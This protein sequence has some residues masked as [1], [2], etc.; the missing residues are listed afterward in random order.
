MQTVAE[1]NSSTDGG[2][3]SLDEDGSPGLDSF[4]LRFTDTTMDGN[5]QYI[6]HASTVTLDASLNP[7]SSD[8]FKV[9]IYLGQI[10][11]NHSWQ[12]TQINLTG[13]SV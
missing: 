5:N 1:S 12:K 9:S 6:P 13:S 2:T 4:S 10:S 8:T 11:A 7:G 3:L